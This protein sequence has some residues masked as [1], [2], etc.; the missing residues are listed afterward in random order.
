MMVLYFMVD[1]RKIA[2]RIKTS[3]GTVAEVCAALLLVLCAH[4]APWADTTRYFGAGHVDVTF[5]T[6]LHSAAVGLWLLGIGLS[7]R[8]KHFSLVCIIVAI[9]NLSMFFLM[10][11]FLQ[12]FNRT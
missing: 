3:A 4:V 8:A 2:T 6:L 10:P 12:P 11:V 5:F 1:G 9:F 7:I